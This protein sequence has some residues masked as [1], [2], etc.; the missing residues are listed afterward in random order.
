MGGA[1]RRR[2]A[3]PDEVFRPFAGQAAGRS[4]CWPGSEIV[5]VLLRECTE[6]AVR[7]QLERAKT[8]KNGPF[9]SEY[10]PA[11]TI[12]AASLTLRGTGDTA[13]NREAL[14]GLLDGKLLQIGGDETLGKGLMWG[15]AAGGGLV[16]TVHRIDQ[17]MAAAAAKVLGA[18][19]GKEV[20]STRELRTRYRQLRVMLHTAG[21]AATY[22]FIASKAGDADDRPAAEKAGQGLPEGGRG[23]PGAA[24]RPGLV[25]RGD[26][27]P[28]D[29]LAVMDALGEMDP[30]AYARASAEA[31]A[32][33]GWL[34]RLADAAWLERDGACLIRG[35]R[36]RSPDR[37]NRAAAAPGRRPGRRRA[38]AAAEPSRRA[39]R[40]LP[41]AA[42]GPRSR[43]PGRSAR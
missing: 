1:D 41:G 10:L 13:D 32:F 36:C 9:Y 24:G 30:V 33:V 31:A 23:D 39:S 12:M 26:R 11:E 17:G 21:L 18:D 38:P 35:G 20:R 43:R 25:S 6:Q 19:G 14:R 8:V 22:A 27:E 5:P 2:R 7:V 28:A 42:P 37:R 15:T 16:M 3:R 29:V 4:R 40:S 34:S